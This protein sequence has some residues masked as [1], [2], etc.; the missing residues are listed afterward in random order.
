[1]MVIAYRYHSLVSTGH[2]C[3]QWWE[4]EAKLEAAERIEGLCIAKTIADA[5]AL[6]GYIADLKHQVGALPEVKK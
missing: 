1:M 5:K 6:H 2:D 4:L 3:K